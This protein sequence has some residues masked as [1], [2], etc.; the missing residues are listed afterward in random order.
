[1]CAAEKLNSP[2]LNCRVFVSVGSAEK[3][4]QQDLDLQHY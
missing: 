4:S 3:L 2:I 1:M